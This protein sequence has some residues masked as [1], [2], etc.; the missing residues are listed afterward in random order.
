MKFLSKLFLG[1][2]AAALTANAAINPGNLP[3]WFEAGHGSATGQFIA[4]GG[5][6][7][8]SI[9]QS[10]ADFVLSKPGAPLETVR[11]QFVGANP[12]PAL[13]GKNALAAKINYFIGHDSAQWQT[14]LPTFG[15][16]QLAQIYPGIDVS[17]YGNRQKLEYDFDLAAGVK[18]ET[19]TIHFDGAEKV[20]V[21]AQSE[22]V[23]QLHG[24]Q[25]VQ[26]APVAYQVVA[27]SRHEIQAGY[28]IVDA[29]SVTF[30]V[31]QFDRNLP[32]VIDPVLSYS[33]YFGGNSG[34]RAWAVA[35]NPADDSIYLAGQT[36]STQVTN[37]LPFAKNGYDTNFNGA[38]QVGD[39]FVARFDSTGT[40]LLY[41]T[42]LG[43]SADDA[44]Y[45][46]AVDAAGHAYVAGV[47]DSTNF[48]VTN[49]IVYGT[50]QGKTIA[51]KK[52]PNTGYF[53]TDGFVAELETNGSS[54]L[55][56]TYLGG[57]S[58]DVVFGL[59]LDSAGDAFVTGFTYSTNFP[60]TAGAYYN[61]LVC[62]NNFYA[63]ANAFVAEISA[64]GTNLNYATYYGGTNFDI[65]R[66]IA[67]NNG[68]V[69]VV[70][71]TTST[72]F[73][74]TNSLVGTRYLNGFATNATSGSDAFVTMFTTSGTNLVLQY[75]TFLGSTNNDV[76]TGIAA[77]AAG[78]AY[79]VGWTTSTN[80]PVTT[81]GVQLSSY[82]RTNQTGFVLATNAFLTKLI[83]DG[84]NVGLNYSQMFGGAGVDVAN[85]LKLDAA[86]NVFIVGSA[87]S[88]NFPVTSGAV[89]GSLRTTNFGGSDVFVTAFKSDFSGLLYS[90]YLGGRQDDFGNAI[91]LDT[92]GNA[93]VAGQTYSTNFPAFGTWSTNNP[94][95]HAKMVGTND[96]FLAKIVTGASPVLSAAPAGTNVLVFWP[97]LSDATPSNL[98]IETATNLL[99]L[100]NQVSTNVTLTH[101]NVVTNLVSVFTTNWAVVTNPVP[102]LVNSNFTYTFTPTNPMRFFRFHN[103]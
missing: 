96:A 78:N 45:A 32:L 72:N 68:K 24:G 13:T 84:T 34:D 1:T 43:G 4:H 95:M 35:V 33:T 49:A 55:Y 80:F 15:Q 74:W 93:I 76:A 73:P 98:G 27:G 36:L 50:F 58:S 99:M 3:L 86:G 89:F 66:A 83:Y 37:N 69:F 91:A 48:P 88:T 81:N 19:I 92:A 14:G 41:C 70:G 62:S 17:Y 51:G 101:T 97:A 52:D 5:D 22:L 7:D 53:P 8:F 90:T 60:T 10:G 46:L 65:G 30:A 11:M 18:P 28:Q 12:T 61:H 85:G 71:S 29:S 87:T 6:A 31:G 2:A 82:V 40:N 64:G 39:A 9:S 77:D 20:S 79:V 102:V 100:Q 67:Y 16:I 38:V 47:T 25:I 54:L 26:H 103:N 57:N 94:A 21:N 42:Y 23:I 63:N 44:V 56:S 75:S 59:D